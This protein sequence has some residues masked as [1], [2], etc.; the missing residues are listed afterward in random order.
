M[1]VFGGAETAGASGTLAESRVWVFDFASQTWSEIPTRDDFYRDRPLPRRDHV[2]I[3]DKETGAVVLYGGHVGAAAVPDTLWLLDTE[4]PPAPEPASWLGLETD[5]VSPGLRAGHSASYDDE[6]LPVAQRRLYIFGGDVAGSVPLQVADPIVY[7]IQPFGAPRNWYASHQAPFTLSGHTADLDPY[8]LMYARTPE[9]FDPANGTWTQNPAASWLQ[10]YYPPTFVVP[11]ND[12]GGGRVVAVG[13]DRQARY[14][15][16]PAAGP[17]GEWRDIGTGSSG[18]SAFSAPSGVMYEPGRI[19]IAG[20]LSP[21]GVVGTSQTLD[22]RN[23]ANGWQPTGTP[24][25]LTP[26]LEHNLVLLPTGDVLAVGG[27]SEEALESLAAVHC[28]QLWSPLTGSWTV[29]GDLACDVSGGSPVVRNYHSTAIL[30]PDAR[31]ISAGGFD[32]NPHRNYAR[33]FCPPYLFKPGVTPQELAPRPVITGAPT[34]LTWGQTFTI[35]TPNPDAV[36]SVALIRAPSTTHS[37]DQNQRFVRLTRIGT[38]SDPPRLFVSAPA[39]REEAPPGDYLLFLVGSSDAGGTYPEAPS[40]AEWVRI[41]APQGADACDQVAPAA[42]ALVPDVIGSSSVLLSWVAPADDGA[43]PVSGKA[44]RYD[45]RKSPF[46]IDSEYAWSY[47][48][49]VPNIPSPDPVGTEQDLLVEDLFPCTVYHFSNRAEDDRP[50]LGPLPA[51]LQITTTCAGGGGGEFAAREV[52]GG[53]GGTGPRTGGR[54]HG[55]LADGRPAGLR[56]DHSTFTAGA[57]LVPGTL[58]VETRRTERG[59]WQVSLR[60]GGEG[61][62]N[63]SAAMVTVDKE[64]VAGR[65]DTVGRFEPGE[66]ETVLGLCALRDRGRV[67]VSGFTGLERL[68]SRVRNRGEDLVLVSAVHSRLGP[69]DVQFLAEG[70]PVVL[71]SVDVIELT[72]EAAADRIEGTPHWYV[73][74]RRVGTAP[75]TPFSQRPIADGP[76]SERFALHRNEPNPTGVPTTIRF[77]LPRASRVRLEVFD[78]LGRHVATLVDAALP[79]GKHSRVWDLRDTNGAAVPP[80]VYACRLVAEEFRAQTKIGVVP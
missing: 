9:T 29:S 34:Q 68:L 57:S 50:N 52:S 32:P 74:V 20:G 4:N 31:V 65:R 21:A 8:G 45:L 47:A 44:S 12:V 48:G 42:I 62:E 17:A 27:V 67:A 78:L 3:C 75:P 60:R 5:G 79:A 56:P 36:E 69:L 77:D 15:D 23:T 63:S 71:E 49:P 30:L 7:M 14:L 26:R 76:S 13:Q 37:F 40:V 19:L 51:D 41:Q 38:A 22:A 33:I 55:G 58:V 28:P 6:K 46:V 18:F 2:M 25:P 59:A 39:S 1:L 54:A 35:C 80:G 61:V 72:Y 66:H 53:E 24:I 10:F 73:L 43:L 11:G 16:I 64:G 70:G